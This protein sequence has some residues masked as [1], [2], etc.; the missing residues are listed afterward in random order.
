MVLW[1]VANQTA[2]PNYWNDYLLTAAAGA[3]A[4]NYPNKKER[5]K[6]KK[7]EDTKTKYTPLT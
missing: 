3:A 6:H 1:P 4:T 5:K 2:S 7:I